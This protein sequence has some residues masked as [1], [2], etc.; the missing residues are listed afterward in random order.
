[1]KK[2]EAKN[3]KFLIG[4]KEVAVAQECKITIEQPPVSH[5]EIKIYSPSGIASWKGEITLDLIPELEKMKTGEEQVITF[6]KKE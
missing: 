3:V 4:G 1:M 6:V 2:L 5:I